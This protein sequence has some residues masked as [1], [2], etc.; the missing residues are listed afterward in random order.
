MTYLGTISMPNTPIYRYLL[1]EHLNNTY[2][3]HPM[4]LSTHPCWYIEGKI[5]TW[6]HYQR[7][8]LLSAQIANVEG[9]RKSLV[10]FFS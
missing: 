8:V 3:Y 7:V 2:P 10:E 4:L 6:A 1:I 9:K 5:A